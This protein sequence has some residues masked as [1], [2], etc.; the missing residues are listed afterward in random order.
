MPCDAGKSSRMRA[1]VIMP[2]SPINTISER[3]NRWRS[4][5]TWVATVLGSEVL[6][7]NTSTATGHPE[8][9][10]SRPKTICSLPDLSSR[11]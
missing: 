4:L 8:A 5:L 2:R 1:L 9:L 7:A 3:P 11:E 6:P 10:V